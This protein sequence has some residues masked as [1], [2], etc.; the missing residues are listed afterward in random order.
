MS[1]GGG[2]D[3]GA[4]KRQA[5]QEAKKQAARDALN[6]LFGEGSG[7]TAAAPTREQFMRTA[8]GLSLPRLRGV[9][10]RVA[11]E[12][13]RNGGGAG[14]TFDQAGYDAALAAYQAA[15]T[16]PNANKAAREKRY[17]DIRTNAYDAGLRDVNEQAADAKRN[18]KFAL[19]AQ[20][21]NGGS[22][23]IDQNARL[24]RVYDQGVLQLGAKAD[25]AAADARGN[26]E[27]TRLALLQ[28]ID[29]GM[30]QGSALSSA[31][32]QQRV[33][34]DKAASAAAQTSVDDLFANAGLLYQQSQA[35]K[36]KQNAVD[37]WNQYG[38]GGN[39]SSKS[40]SGIV[41]PTY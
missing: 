7:A 5:E 27:S 22:E 41:T 35:A 11:L 38:T 28:S 4:S 18:T 2:G 13:A 23:D 3:G 29:A 33:N 26:D 16:S 40:A 1:S 36:G 8:N 10:S 21:L 31:L 19:F 34:A 17:S 24:K 37:W 30:D 6:A 12:T 20:G 39:K 14:V 25:A 9:T 32:A 15:Q